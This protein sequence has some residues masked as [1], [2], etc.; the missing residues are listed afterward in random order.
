MAL[1]RGWEW[2]GV[3]GAMIES[4]PLLASRA[5]YQETFAKGWGAW[6]CK[7]MVESSEDL[8]TIT[9]Y[10]NAFNRGGE[11]GVVCEAI[12]KKNKNII[13]KE[14]YLQAKGLW[15]SCDLIDTFLNLSPKLLI[16]G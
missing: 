13:T 15:W 9:N 14:R 8:A 11:W 7:K 5:R 1:K 10:N 16:S 2:L 12:V 4:N 3:C 6:L